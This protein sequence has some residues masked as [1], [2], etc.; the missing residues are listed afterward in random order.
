[1]NRES[2]H[3]HPL[4]ILDVS[5][6]FQSCGSQA[7]LAFAPQGVLGNVWRQSQPG[8]G[9]KGGHWLLVGMSQSGC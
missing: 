6:Y 1:M 3:P 5:V 8:S 4:G 9:E 2:T 7:R